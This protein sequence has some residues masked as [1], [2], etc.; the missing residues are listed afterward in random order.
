MIPYFTSAICFYNRKQ[1]SVF[2][3]VFVVLK[4][5]QGVL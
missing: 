1:G 3:L 4:R 5:L 2:R